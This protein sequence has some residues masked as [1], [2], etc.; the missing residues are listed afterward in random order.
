MATT[1]FLFFFYLNHI[2]YKREK[3]ENQLTY[4]FRNTVSNNNEYKFSVFAARTQKTET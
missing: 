2:L 1:G 4:A 3:I